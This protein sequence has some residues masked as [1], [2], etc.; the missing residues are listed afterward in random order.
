LIIL[1]VTGPSHERTAKAAAISAAR[2]I[3]DIRVN[4]VWLPSPCGL[5]PPIEAEHEP[6]E[7]DHDGRGDPTPFGIPVYPDSG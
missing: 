5:G 3:L 2:L 4:S 1:T 7:E 6:G